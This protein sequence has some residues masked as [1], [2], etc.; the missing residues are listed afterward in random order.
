MNVV[1]YMRR[2]AVSGRRGRVYLGGNTRSTG[3]GG[4]RGNRGADGSHGAGGSGSLL[5][6]VGG[7]SNN[8]SG[9]AGTP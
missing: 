9:G 8:P 2:V 1:R 3:P 6:D 4:T 5:D 7:A